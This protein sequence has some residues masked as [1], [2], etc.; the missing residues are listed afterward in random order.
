MPTVSPA[1][2]SPSP[3]LLQGGTDFFPALIAAID[4]AVV[5]VQLETYLF[6]F[7]GAGGDVAEALIRA[8]RRGLTVQVLV[9]GLG[10]PPL[11]AGWVQKFAAA[12]VFWQV[13]SP[14]TGHWPRLGL[15]RPDRWRRLHRK[16]CV[17]DQQQVFCGGINVLDDFYDPRHGSL[18][19]PRFDFA[20]ALH[21]PVA[22]AASEAMALLWW[23]VQAG[24]SARR[25]HLVEA[26]E[27]FKAAGYGGRISGAQ[28]AGRR[29]LVLSGRAVDG[30]TSKSQLSTRTALLN[31]DNLLNSN[32]IER[33]YR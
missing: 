24:Y 8:G 4:G 23:R 28:L 29:G 9:D 32:I 13:Y 7:H 19:A 6:D 25:H 14:L 16:L 20:V 30:P 22:E 15:V 33:A 1:A 12:G 17:I 21:G 3:Q 2:A 26:W 31:R 18:S 27:A 5:W 11:Q 10:S